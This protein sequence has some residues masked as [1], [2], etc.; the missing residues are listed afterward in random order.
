LVEPHPTSR[1]GFSQ[2]VLQDR[3][4]YDVVEQNDSPDYIED[5]SITCSLPGENTSTDV[6]NES[7]IPI[8]EGMSF[9]D[10]LVSTTQNDGRLDVGD[11]TSFS[12]TLAVSTGQEASNVGIPLMVDLDPPW[13]YDFNVIDWISPDP[14]APGDVDTFG[15][16]TPSALFTDVSSL[17]VPGTMMGHAEAS[18]DLSMRRLA[19]VS[20]QS[21]HSTGSSNRETASSEITLTQ[22]RSTPDG[23]HGMVDGSRHWPTNWNPTKQDNV[24]SFP[25][26]S[27]LT[28]DI[29]DAEDLA[30]VES[31]SPQCY[32]QIMA[33]LH[34]HANGH[35]HFRAFVN[36][37]LP[38]LRA[39]NCFVQLY[40]EHFQPIFPLLHQGTFDPSRE[41]WQLVLAVSAVGCRY[42]RVPGSLQLANALQEL[43]R[44]T[45]AETVSLISTLR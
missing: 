12:S 44:R 28:N 39:M 13:N 16:E 2:Q 18:R 1:E 4:D 22:N 30:H 31:I 6:R 45:I 41:P 36:A 14:L 38:G 21:H 35:S 23:R 34:R 24:V 32:S 7:R 25:D 29:L 26:T 15:Q 10:S 37:E 11:I 43:V 17:L 19:V 42:S 40:F 5:Y 20:P 27:D 9:V 33:C 3:P 8:S